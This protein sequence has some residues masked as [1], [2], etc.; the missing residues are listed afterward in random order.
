MSGRPTKIDI[1]RLAYL[2]EERGLTY[3]QISKV[4]GLSVGALSWQC[5]RHGIEHP[6]KVNRL[7]TPAASTE[8]RGGHVVRRYSAE[9]D[10]QIQQWVMEG[11]SNSEIGRRLG[12]AP[13]SIANRLMTLARHEARKGAA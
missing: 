10:A 7:R 11:L 13:N 3:G 1:E 6:S 2:R 5:L 8:V 9:D 4:M 12:R